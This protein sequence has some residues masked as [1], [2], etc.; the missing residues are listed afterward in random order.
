[1]AHYNQSHS[2]CKQLVR[3]QQEPCCG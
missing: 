2:H 1:M 3:L